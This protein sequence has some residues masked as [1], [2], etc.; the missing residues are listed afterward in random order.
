MNPDLYREIMQD[1]NEKQ[2]AAQR[3]RESRIREV[4]L[5]IPRISQIDTELLSFTRSL[6]LIMKSADISQRSLKAQGLKAK[7]KALLA[8][9]T[10]LLEEN[11]Y[12]KDYLENVYICPHCR[13]TGYVGNTPCSC[14]K[15]AE[16]EKL[17]EK[18]AMKSENSDE[19][20]STFS[21]DYYSDQINPK[22]KTSPRNHMERVFKFCLGFATEPKGN[23]IFTGSPGLGKS[24][25]CHAIAK[26]LLEKNKEVICGSAFT[27]LDRLISHRFG[28]TDE[29]D[30]KNKVMNTPTLIIDDLG[31][32]NTNSAANAELF[33][34][35]NHRLINALP[36]VIST[37][38][39][40]A[41][42]KE[43][44]SERIFSR[45]MG[46]YTILPFYGS[47]IRIIKRR[48]G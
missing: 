5:K 19:A 34:L 9:K 47:D 36:T 11:G 37:N 23:L 7:T 32:E 29:T 35:L 41:E 26:E 48:E 25:L 16:R 38:L 33:N 2:I 27:I 10:R 46:E 20:F 45:I 28:R 14:F 22:L 3:L 18:S 1:Y 4:S 21:L 15:Q 40:L 24:F 43:V 12:P 8:E 30:F 39:S 6:A 17:Y 13:D 44:Y 42:L 31:T